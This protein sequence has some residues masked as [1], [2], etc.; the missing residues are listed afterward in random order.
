[1]DKSEETKRIL[2]KHQ[3]ARSLSTSFTYRIVIAKKNPRQ[4]VKNDRSPPY[5]VTQ[6][7]GDAE[8]LNSRALLRQK[9]IQ[10]PTKARALAAAALTSSARRLSG[11][12]TVCG[13]KSVAT[14]GKCEKGV[15]RVEESLLSVPR[16]VL[17][18]A[19]WLSVNKSRRSS[20]PADVTEQKKVEDEQLD[21]SLSKDNAIEPTHT[22]DTK[23][24][25]DKMLL[26]LEEELLKTPKSFKAGASFDTLFAREYFS[27]AQNEEL[28]AAAVVS[29][30]EDGI[31]K[32]GGRK[33]S[34]D[35]RMR[36]SFV[37]DKDK[38][39]HKFGESAER[40]KKFLEFDDRPFFSEI[41]NRY[42][43]LKLSFNQAKT[44]LAK[45]QATFSSSTLKET[46]KQILAAF[47]HNTA[48]PAKHLQRDCIITAA[49][50]RASEEYLE[51]HVE[52]VSTVVEAIKEKCEGARKSVAVLRF[53]YAVM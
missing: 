48:P 4:A 9:S 37:R 30:V 22:Q 11:Q 7:F 50:K 43:D 3:S 42:A 27:P 35:N 47:K 6:S 15:A 53:V 2:P 5:S 32:E 17:R 21:N 38:A 10:A 26:K 23:S 52:S 41:S 8:N 12:G 33:E 16:S 34:G 39:M 20:S 14:P 31:V 25:T 28:K 45:F 40:I 36:L 1:M 13:R 19:V 51:R 46:L 29:N 49:L 24:H 18:D 44:S